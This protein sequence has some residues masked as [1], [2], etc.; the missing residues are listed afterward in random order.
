MATMH[1][2]HEIDAVQ[3][4]PRAGNPSVEVVDICSIPETCWFK[5]GLAPKGG[6]GGGSRDDVWAK[7]KWARIRGNECVHLMFNDSLPKNIERYT[8]HT[9]VSN[10]D[11][12]L[13]NR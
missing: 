5:S 9:I 10:H 2:K 1:S 11:L 3:A 4:I 13:N 7:T 6:G 8:A 12:T